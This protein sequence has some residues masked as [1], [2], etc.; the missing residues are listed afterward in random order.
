MSELDEKTTKENNS[1]EQFSKMLR[2]DLDSFGGLDEKTTINN[3]NTAVNPDFDLTARD[4]LDLIG[5]DNIKAFLN[6][7]EKA[8]AQLALKI[9]PEKDRGN[10]KI[11]T[12]NDN[13][14]A[15]MKLRL[16]NKILEKYGSDLNVKVSPEIALAAITVL[17]VG[18]VFVQTR[19]EATRYVADL[20]RI[21]GVNA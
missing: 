1:V 10:F 17:S 14:F 9:I 8:S 12:T 21:E 20:Q 7:P 18:M 15:D 13:K 11:G 5:D 4:L 19:A 6:F 3:Q 16:A 2:N